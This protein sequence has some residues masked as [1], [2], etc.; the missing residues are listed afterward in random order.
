MLLLPLWRCTPTTHQWFSFYFCTFVVYE[1]R[2]SGCFFFVIGFPKIKIRET[3]FVGAS[4]VY[5]RASY[6]IGLHALVLSLHSLADRYHFSRSRINAVIEHQSDSHKITT[7]NL[8]RVY[9]SEQRRKKRIELKRLFKFG[10]EIFFVL[11]AFSCSQSVFIS[12]WL[13]Y[14][15]RWCQHF[16]FG[17][18]KNRVVLP[19]WWLLLI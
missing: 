18:C 7:F 12:F 8:Q 1:T 15:A 3:V 19:S 16:M 2:I 11:F 4:C 6:E 14:P 13:T 9:E 17:Y 5:T 10:S